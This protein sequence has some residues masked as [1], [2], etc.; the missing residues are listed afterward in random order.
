MSVPSFGE[1]NFV[2]AMF[3]RFRLPVVTNLAVMYV[4]CSPSVLTDLFHFN[5]FFGQLNPKLL[6]FDYCYIEAVCDVQVEYRMHISRKRAAEGEVVMQ[7]REI[8]C[9]LS[10]VHICP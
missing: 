4:R 5:M 6:S 7:N 9:S 3:V 10:A 1:C 2:F 8:L